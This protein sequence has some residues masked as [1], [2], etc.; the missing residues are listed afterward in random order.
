M[1]NEKYD[2]DKQ[3]RAGVDMNRDPIT[4]A[5]GSHPVGTGTGAA[6]G[7][8]VGGVVGA[9]GGPIGVAAGAA[10]GGVAGGLVGKSTAEAVNPTGEVEYWKT[11]FANRPY[12]RNASWDDFEPAYFASA[13][14]YDTYWGKPF[15]EVEPELQ[16]SW[17]KNRKNS[18]LEWI[19]ARNA[20]KDAWDR[21]AKRSKGNT[22]D[23][24]HEAA[25]TANDLVE[26]LYDGAKG[27]G[28]AADS[29]KNPTYKD[30]LRRF[31]QQREQF[32]G[33]LK[34]LIA[35]RGEKPESS[36]TVRGALHRGWIGIKNAVTSG[37]HAIL[38]ECERGEDAAVAKY[39]K[40]LESNELTPE[41]R[42]VLQSQFTQVQS[43]HNTVRDWRDMT[44]ATKS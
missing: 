7:A 39:R 4:G 14:M 6:I 10:I 15:E 27:F 29:V 12:A 43:A 41:L 44:A 8:T 24:E 30:G 16:R 18:R 5:P 13:S 2:S 34:P 42:R 26:F 20:S 36:G 25:E 19:D 22:S 1:A 38:A 3:T 21:L 32:I 35:S 11:E 28:Q 17:T 33:E 40:V 37:D 31:S 23:S 9:I